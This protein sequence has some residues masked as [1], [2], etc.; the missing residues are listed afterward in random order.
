M[1]SASKAIDGFTSIFDENESNDK[2]LYYALYNL[3][4]TV[5]QASGIAISNAMREVVTLWNNTFGEADYSLKI[6]TYDV[7]R[8]TNAEHLYSALVKGDKDRIEKLKA[9]F[10]SEEEMQSALKTVIRNHYTEGDI[11]YDTTYKLLKEYAGM[12][13][14]DL[15]WYMDKL[16][17]T[18]DNGSSEGY[19]KYDE[20]ISAVET[21][22]N[23]KSV[24]NHYL[25]K[26]VKKETLAGQI[27]EHFKPLYKQMSNAERSKLK[28]Y[29]LN[30]YVLLGYNRS[31]RSK[32]INNWLKED[33]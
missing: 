8:S 25:E 7:G 21:G 18:I 15:Y 20:F 4:K 17:Y 16:D 9:L 23:L 19:E 29:L 14:N 3:T 13:D 24:I 2:P 6:R 27:T 32:A 1:G 5:S 28:G 11:D 12:D 31:D 26:G 33:S 30:A 10:A 22:A